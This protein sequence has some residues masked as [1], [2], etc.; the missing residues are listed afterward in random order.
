MKGQETNLD[1]WNRILEHNLQGKDR[2]RPLRS[3]D[4]SCKM[5]KSLTH[6]VSS[7]RSSTALSS[8]APRKHSF[9]SREVYHCFSLLKVSKRRFTKVD[10]AGNLIERL[11]TGGREAF[12][13]GVG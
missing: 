1:A 2:A 8:S 3:P 10:T 9:L 12:L 4:R 7:D 11:T 6:N 5:K 13:G